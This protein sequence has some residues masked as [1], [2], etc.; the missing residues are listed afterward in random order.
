MPPVGRN[1][2][3]QESASEREAIL[4][5]L[6]HQ[7]ALSRSLRASARSE[8]EQGQARQRLRA[9]QSDRLAR[10]HADLLADPQFGRAAQFFLSDLYG[11]TDHGKF[12]LEVER[13]VP[14]MS[15]LLPV[16][17]LETVADAVELDALSEV[18]DAAM[19]AALGSGIAALDGSAYARA[20][21][22]VGRRSDRKRQIR[23]IADLGQ[24]L[25]RLTRQ[26]FVAGALVMMRAPARLAGLGELQDFLQRGFDAL[27]G[28]EQSDLFLER[29]VTRELGLLEALFAGDDSPLDE[30]G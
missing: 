28:M 23:L 20:Y 12:D 18:L 6:R 29:I 7:L 9:W 15:R 10:T 19:V 13:V 1:R 8:Q 21:R 17:G 24:A 27:K 14:V 26:P 11:P 16:A 30:P 22:Q 2:L 4:G 25:A 3:P 5:R